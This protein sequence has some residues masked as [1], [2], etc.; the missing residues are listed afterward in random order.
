MDIGQMVRE[1]VSLQEAQNRLRV[2]MVL[3][4]I[5][6]QQG[7]GGRAAARLGVHRNTVTRILNESGRTVL[8][9]R[10]GSRKRQKKTVLCVCA[11]AHRLSRRVFLLET[12]GYN[13]L[14]AGNATVA[15]TIL[16]N[17]LQ[18]TVDLLLTE[19]D[20]PKLDGERLIER[21]KVLHPE[22]PSLLLYPDVTYPPSIANVVLPQGLQ[23]AGTVLERIRILTVRKRGPKKQPRERLKIEHQAMH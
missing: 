2:E 21:A 1:G 8:Q 18:G 13:V 11:N 22:L 4:V 15:V 17:R 3:E 9:I 19:M 10:R 12:R 23:D 6:Q 5:K 20:L 14:R 7:S 16:S